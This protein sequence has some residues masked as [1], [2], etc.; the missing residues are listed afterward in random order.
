MLPG[1]TLEF[2]GAKHVLAL[3]RSEN[4]MP[5]SYTVM[6]CVS[7]GKFP[8]VLFLTLQ[9][10]KGV[11]GPIVKRAM[12][13]T[14]NLHVI[15]ST[16]GK[17]TEQLLIEWCEK[18]FFP[19]MHHYCIFLAEF[20]PT[21]ADEDVVEEIK[22]GELEYEIITIPPKVTSQIQPLDVLCFR[23]YKG[24]FRKISNWIFLND[25]PGQVHHRD[26]IIKLHSLIYQ[27]FTSPRFQNL[28]EQ[29]WHLSGYINK[30]FTSVNPTEFSFD[31]LTGHCDHDSCSRSLLL[32]FGWC[33]AP[34]C[35]HHF[36][37]RYHFC[38]MYLP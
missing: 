13:K 22:P 23:M 11:L 18:V 32:K 25:Q 8:P 10:D 26:L 27:Q 37:E 30:S 14:R 1:R 2:V 5:H 36:R 35:F 20:W 9:E 6:I 31:G 29:G 4:S 34:L 24:Y 33:K 38:K 7:P 16:S 15:A 12:Y 19:H 21:F 17:M 28:I 3:T